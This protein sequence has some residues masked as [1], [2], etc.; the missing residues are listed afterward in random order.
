MVD[1]LLEELILGEQR[2]HPRLQLVVVELQ[3]CLTGEEAIDG[4]VVNTWVCGWSGRFRLWCASRR[5]DRTV[6]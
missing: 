2:P 4:H 5:D 1:A 6:G 3:D